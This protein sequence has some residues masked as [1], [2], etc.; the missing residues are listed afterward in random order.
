MFIGA[1]LREW[2]CESFRACASMWHAHAVLASCISRSIASSDAT[3]RCVRLHT[4]RKS[5]DVQRRLICNMCRTSCSARPHHRP[6]ASDNGSKASSVNEGRLKL[7]I[8]SSNT[9]E[10]L[11]DMSRT[12]GSCVGH[13]VVNEVVTGTKTKKKN[14][15]MTVIRVRMELVMVIVMVITK[16]A[17]MWF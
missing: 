4:F 9:Q 2:G 8:N 14:V 3:G 7:S 11:V 10:V 5:T 13:E 16:I 1:C 17:F 12:R 6:I 15:M